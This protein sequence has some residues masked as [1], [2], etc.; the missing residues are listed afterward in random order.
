MNLPVEVAR[1]MGAER[2]IAVDV[3]EKLQS[4]EEIRSVVDVTEQ[5]TSMLTVRGTL[6]QIALLDERDVLLTPD[7]SGEYSSVTFARLAETIDAGYELVMERRDVFEPYALSA[8][9]YAAYRTARPDPRI[10]ELPPID[11]IRFGET[12]PLAESVIEARIEEIEIGQTL[13]LDA[14]ERSLNRIYGLGFYQNVRY[15]LVQDGAR[16]GLDFDLVERSWGPSYVQL[17]LRYASATNED[18]RFGL[19]ASYLRTGIN[20]RGGEWRATF[21]LGDEPGFIADW[22]QPL[23]DKALTFVNPALTTGS[24][25]L[26]V[27]EDGLL[28]AEVK[29]R[30]ATFEFGGGRELLDWAEIRGGFRVGAGDTELRVGDPAA[31]PFDSFHRGE[32]FA[33]FSVDTFDNLGFPRDGT[34]ATFEWRGSD[35]GALGAD[36]D[37]DQLSM[38]ASHARTWG[39]HTLL[40]SLRYDTTVSG[41]TPLFSLFRLGG[42]RDLAGLNIGELTGQ[43]VTRLGASYYRRIG[44]L[45]LFPA[46]VGLS[47]EVGNAW[48]SRDDISLNRSIWGGSVW[49]GV[50]T[51][52]GPV[53][54]AYG[55][56]EGGEDAF[57]VFL[58]RLF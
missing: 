39:R 21:L 23:G 54:L 12:A 28:A 35:S 26:N 55:S 3:S 8:E 7:F 30:E 32:L 6:D 1:A 50:D 53:F 43:H 24:S 17:G 14:F 56:A 18:A 29:L 46:F 42:F 16:T 52:A 41:Q 13:D 27:F 40:T 51:P 58:G 22:H 33:R 4:R 49:A 45:A 57:Y 19:A 38:R 5:L 9:D 37:Y 2:I 36:A 44:D 47:A 34:Y 10:T 20:D 48:Q 11:F 15:A 31:V 25:I